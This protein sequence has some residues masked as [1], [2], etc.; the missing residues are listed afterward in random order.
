LAS[1]LAATG[2]RLTWAAGLPLERRVIASAP[3]FHLDF[4]ATDGRPE[5]MM[6]AATG[7]GADLVVFDDADL[8]SNADGVV[9]EK[10]L[11]L[12]QQGR[13]VIVTLE[14]HSA[15]SALERVARAA[16]SVWP[17][18]AS[19]GRL[20]RVCKAVLNERLIFG[21]QDKRV[22][23]FER[24]L[25]QPEML[26]AIERA[27]FGLLEECFGRPLGGITSPGFRESLARLVE[28]DVIDERNAARIFDCIR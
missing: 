1:A 8:V 22:A 2:Q 27:Q 9:L 4:C 23:L 20:A 16:R 14:A 21:R 26:E 6:T 12:A 7:V 3:V 18:T 24:I 13:T 11:I 15:L 28:R 10:A 19:A 25:V 17:Q 5:T